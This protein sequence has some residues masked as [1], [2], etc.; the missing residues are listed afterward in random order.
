MGKMRAVQVPGPKKPFELVEKEIPSPK[1]GVF[2][3]KCKPVEFAIVILLQKRDSFQA[4]NT[5]EFP[6]MKLRG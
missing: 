1:E 5:Q 6:V 3:L 4:F 2:A